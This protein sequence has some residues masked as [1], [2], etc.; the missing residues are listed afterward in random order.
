MPPP[1]VM[2]SCSVTD[3]S[4]SLMIFPQ[5]QD[6]KIQ[7]ATNVAIVIGDVNHVSL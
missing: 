2:I 7:E 1:I 6:Y 4:N 5:N 3:L